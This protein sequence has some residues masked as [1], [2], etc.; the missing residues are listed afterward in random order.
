MNNW[1]AIAA[2]IIFGTATGATVASETKATSEMRPTLWH[3]GLVVSNLITM[4]LF[5]GDVI[6]LQRERQLLVEDSQVASGTEG[7]IVGDFDALMAVNGTRIEIRQYS[8]PRNQKFFEL[9]HFPD[10]PAQPVDRGTDHPLGLSHVGLSVTSIDAVLD[11]MEQWGL[12][13]LMSGPQKLEEFGGLRIAF[14]R[15]PEGNIVEL[16]E[17]GVAQP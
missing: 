15:D 3:V 1:I 7:A 9:L 8:E 6:G 11:R 14:L 13:K 16:M 4:D 5:Y 17:A 2:F 10:H 12:G